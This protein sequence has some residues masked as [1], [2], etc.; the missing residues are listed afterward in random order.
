MVFITRLLLNTQAWITCSMLTQLLS[1]I[2]G[3]GDT[4]RLSILKHE[5]KQTWQIKCLR[6]DTS[7]LI[8]TDWLYTLSTVADCNILLNAKLETASQD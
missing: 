5:I 7:P 6:E 1:R 8:I 3:L 4:D 2:L